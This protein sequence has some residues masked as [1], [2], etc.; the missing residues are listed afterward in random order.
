MHVVVIG[1]GRVGSELAG[2]LPSSPATR[3]QSSTRTD[4]RSGDCP[5]D[6]GGKTIVGFGFDRDH[7]AEAGHRQAGAFASVTNGD[8]S[9]ILCAR[10]ARETYRHRARRRPHLRPAP[11]ARSTNGS[12][13]R[14]SRPSRGRPIRCCGGSSR[15]DPPRLGRPHRQGRAR[16]APDPAAA[17]RPQAGRAQPARA[18]CGYRGDPVRAGARRHRRHDRPRRRRAHVRRRA[19]D[20]LDELQEHI[21]PAGGAL[22]RVA[23]AGAGNVGTVHRQ[24][25]GRAPA[26]RCC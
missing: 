22:M 9:N 8:N 1:C 4:G 19:M 21:E 5:P 7:L 20:A 26:T 17:G 13:S 12:A 23:I 24:R 15:R 16:R 3:S 14:R 25:P 11:R 2:A 18:G 10:I 6:F